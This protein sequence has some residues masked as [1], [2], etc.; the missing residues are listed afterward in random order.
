MA[1]QSE[2]SPNR[3]ST[4]PQPA[5][6]GSYKVTDVLWYYPF[7]LADMSRPSRGNI[8]KYWAARPAMM[9]PYKTNLR[10]GFYSALGWSWIIQR[11][12]IGTPPEG[13]PSQQPE[14]KSFWRIK[15]QNPKQFRT[16]FSAGRGW[17]AD[18]LGSKKPILAKLLMME[19]TISPLFPGGINRNEQFDL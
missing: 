5:Q 13:L 16:V 3:L 15:T 9:S 4:L 6:L 12:M 2:V 1:S 10:S 8:T 17:Q 11:L 7:A 14:W 19:T 18:L